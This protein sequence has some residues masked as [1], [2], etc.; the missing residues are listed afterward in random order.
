MRYIVLPLLASLAVASPALANEAR[1]EARGGVVWDGHGSEATAGVAAG[2][3]WDLGGST[4]V[5]LETSA[6]KILTNGQRVT[7]GIGGRAGVNT[8]ADG[9]LYAVS[10]YQSKNC[11]TCKEYVSLGAGYQHSLGKNLYGKAEYRHNF[12]KNSSDYDAALVGLGMK[13]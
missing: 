11:K 5:G 9:K 6:D 4:F 7:F 12:V 13:F 2:Y 8:S 1:V 3:D 10:T